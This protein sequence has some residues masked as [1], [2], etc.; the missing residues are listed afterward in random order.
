MV[1]YDPLVSNK[2]NLVGYDQ[3]KKI[4]QNVMD[5]SKIEQKTGCTGSE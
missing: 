1:G 4:G 5:S 2:N 3:L